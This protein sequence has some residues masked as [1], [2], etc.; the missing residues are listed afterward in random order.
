MAIVVVVL[1]LG[2]KNRQGFDIAFI[3]S[4]LNVY[5]EIQEI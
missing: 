4:R 3:I 1:K 5:N 2:K